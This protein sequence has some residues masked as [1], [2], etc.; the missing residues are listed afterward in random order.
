MLGF[1]TMV[2]DVV[3]GFQVVLMEAGRTGVVDGL[4]QEEDDFLTEVVHGLLDEGVQGLLVVHGLVEMGL[5]EVHGLL[6]EGVT[7]VQGLLVVQ[8]LLEEGVIGVQGLLVVE[9]GVLVER[10][11]VVKV[12]VVQLVVTVGLPAEL[13]VCT[14]QCFDVEVAGWMCTSIS[15][16]MVG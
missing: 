5:V 3:A 13:V 12:H 14:W 11:D 9:Q 16:S 4:G 8:G 15:P 6:E 1:Q 7:G 10:L 2:Q